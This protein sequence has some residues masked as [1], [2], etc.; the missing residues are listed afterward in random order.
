MEKINNYK[1]S[2]QSKMT[3]ALSS[4]LA[5]ELLARGFKIALINLVGEAK[6]ILHFHIII[7][8]LFCFKFT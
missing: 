5:V 6:K 2:S 4:N 8:K 7:K 3:V 1:L